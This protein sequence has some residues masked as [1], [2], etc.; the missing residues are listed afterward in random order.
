[1]ALGQ[2]KVSLFIALLR[3]VIL[4]I[5][6]ALILPKFMG[7]KGVYVAEPVADILSVT[8]T[9]ILFIITVRKVLRKPEE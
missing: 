9:S 5:P 8:A 2:A 3:K 1:M 4:L 6:L 7:V